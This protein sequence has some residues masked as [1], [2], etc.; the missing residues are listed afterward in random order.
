VAPGQTAA[1]SVTA[2]G[3]NLTYLWSHDGTAL[4][5]AGNVSGV[6]TATLT[7][8]SASTADDGAYRCLVSNLCGQIMSQ[9]ATLIVQSPP[10]P[11]PATPCG[12][13]G[14]GAAMM[15]PLGAFMMFAGRR[16]R[17]RWWRIYG[18]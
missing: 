4:A 8:G 5:D 14:A 1:F 7:I 2:L 18:K 11:Q 3:N 15:M 10:P 9:S 16:C 6:T 12:T 17:K 13:C